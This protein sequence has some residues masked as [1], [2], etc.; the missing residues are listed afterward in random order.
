MFAR[1]VK[2]KPMEGFG[3]RLAQKIAE[4][5]LNPRQVALRSGVDYPNLTKILNSED[6]APTPDMLNRLETVPE[7]RDFIADEKT[8]QM[9]RYYGEESALDAAIKVFRKNPQRAA[10][11]KSCMRDLLGGI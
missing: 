8:E 10:R 9:L 5:G 11:I 6:K 7:I 2:M 4:V 1:N 3:S